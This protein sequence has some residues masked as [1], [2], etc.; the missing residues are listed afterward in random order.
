MS[1]TEAITVEIP[2][3]VHDGQTLRVRGKGDAGRRGGPAGDLYVTL[4]IREDP[5]FTRD[6]DDIK[7]TLTLPVTDAI[8]GT[9]VSVETVHGPIT[10]KIPEGTQPQQVFRLK[11]KGLPSLRGGRIG[12]HYVVVQVEVPRKLSREEHKLLEEWRSMRG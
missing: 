5:R 2:P 1:S 10:L 7:G 12:D 9:Q 3:G 4:R 6:G 11:G 8:L